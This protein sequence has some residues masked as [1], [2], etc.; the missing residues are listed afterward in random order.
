MPTP[1]PLDSWQ[2]GPWNRWAYQH[3]EEMVPTVVVAAGRAGA[4]LPAAAGPDRRRG[5]GVRRRVAVVRDGAFVLERYRNGMGGTTLHL[6]QSVGKSVLGLLAGVLRAR[7]GGRRRRAR[8]RGGR[9]RL[10]RRARAAPAGHDGGD[11]LRRGLRGGLLA[12][13]RRLRLAPA[14]P[15]RARRDDPRVPADD[16]P[17]AWSTA[18]ACTTRRR[19][20][21]CSASSPSAPAARR[22]R[23]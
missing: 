7:S 4:E 15:R 6:S 20:R 9:Q 16:R 12:L 11:R 5:S 21:T 1:A 8:A 19:T 3:V 17:A 23:S 18:S 13:R 2:V 22:W 10:R 14:P